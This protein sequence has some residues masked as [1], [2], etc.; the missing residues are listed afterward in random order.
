M[1]Y[2][3]LTPTFRH[4]ADQLAYALL[5]VRSMICCKVCLT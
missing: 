2:S 4:R 3:W 5:W 1:T